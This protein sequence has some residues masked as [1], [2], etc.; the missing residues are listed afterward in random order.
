[1]S[2][3]KTTNNIESIFKN[4]PK[5]TI[6]EIEKKTNKL[7]KNNYFPENDYD[8]YMNLIM[9]VLLFNKNC[10]L[11]KIFKDFM[12]LDYIN[13]LKPKIPLKEI[14]K[15][16]YTKFNNH[17]NSKSKENNILE[18]IMEV[19]IFNKDCHLVTVF[20]DYM[21]WDYIDEFLKRF[22]NRD[23]GK[24]RVPRYAHFYRNYC[25]F[26]CRPTFRDFEINEIIQDHSEKKAE[27]YYNQ[28]F[29]KKNEK[30][31]FVD[32]GLFEDDDSESIQVSKSK[33]EKTI[34]NK[35]IKKNIEDTSLYSDKNE[36]ALFY[37][38][39][40]KDIIDNNNILSISSNN[41]SIVKII[42]D[43]IKKD[44]IVNQDNINKES[45]KKIENKKQESNS[46][47][48]E[49][50]KTEIKRKETKTEN[51]SSDKKQD[52]KKQENNNDIDDNRIKEIKKLEIKSHQNNNNTN[53]NNTNKNINNN[54][55]TNNNN[56]NTNNN[57]INN[58]N[59]I[60]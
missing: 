31:K 2:K 57:T 21:I 7:F 50:N 25:K 24:D 27:L 39:P 11:I 33:I 5:L 20:K 28:N 47:H 51:K 45:N 23:E 16:V 42:D 10:H 43:V 54:N 9:E 1:M 36:S 58:N 35:T 44:I 55:N 6:K 32:E 59:K 52:N 56:N 38:N 13:K 4:N 12:I 40:E 15:I 37:L 46:N 17:F 48:K 19:L 14:E 18:L 41:Q 60:I 22:Y 26:F 30:N 34:F 53:V 8:N 3:Q 29:R 49:N